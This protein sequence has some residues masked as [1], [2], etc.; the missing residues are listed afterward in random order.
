M[1]AHNKELLR[2]RPHRPPPRLT[3]TVP[4]VS[5]S[6]KLAC[7]SHGGIAPLLCSWGFLLKDGGVPSV[8]HLEVKIN[9]NEWVQGTEERPS[10]FMEKPGEIKGRSGGR[11]HC[12][13]CQCGMGLKR[14]ILPVAMM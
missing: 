12:T 9:N 4:I 13:D 2:E 3:T 14:V 6:V 10:S 7:V 1:T 8:N 5:F 11:P